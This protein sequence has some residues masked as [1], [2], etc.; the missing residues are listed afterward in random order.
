MNF[1]N[2]P[3]WIDLESVIPLAR[4]KRLNKRHDP[5]E[6]RRSAEQIT[7]LSADTIKRLHPELIIELS[8]RRRGIKLRDALAIAGGIS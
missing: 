5:S 2:P 3:S 7:G 6:E 1:H 8:E 4:P